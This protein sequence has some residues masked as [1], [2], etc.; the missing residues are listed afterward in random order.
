MNNT[1][2]A[3]A[4]CLTLLCICLPLL[5][6]F[7][8]P[9]LIVDRAS[10]LRDLRTD[11]L[12]NID[13][14]YIAEGC[15]GGMGDRQLIR[16]TTHIKNIGTTDFV[17]GTPPADPSLENETWEYDQC[18]DHWH[19]EGYAQYLL[20]D[21]A[22]N[23]IPVGLKNGFCLMDSECDDGGTRQYHCGYQGVSAGCGEF[24]AGL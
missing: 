4:I 17:V 21:Q 3:I 10:L 23:E 16:F 11:L 1:S 5:P 19:Y 7:A 13:P 20:F 2:K 12:D 22:G 15:V 18:H 14:C 6:L 9:D 24:M 8:Q